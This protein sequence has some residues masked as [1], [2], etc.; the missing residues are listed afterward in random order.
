V[1]GSGRQRWGE[2]GGLLLTG[3]G[4]RRSAITVGERQ[5][6]C[7]VSWGWGVHCVAKCRKLTAGYACGEGG[8]APRTL[9]GCQEWLWGQLW[10]GM[11]GWWPCCIT[12]CQPLSWGHLC[13]TK[14][15]MKCWPPA[16]KLS[17]HT[18]SCSSSSVRVWN[19]T[20][21]KG[22]SNRLIFCF[23]HKSSALPFLLVMS[24]MAQCKKAGMVWGKKKPERP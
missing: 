16:R 15:S 8:G 10:S 5:T 19:G 6:W 18:A 24:P 1:E 4:R 17:L 9:E 12:S 20:A 14:L 13:E 11:L 7:C 3:S 21:A 23:L 2:A 22:I